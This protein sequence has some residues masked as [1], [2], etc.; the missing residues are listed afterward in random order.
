MLN[1]QGNFCPPKQK[2]LFLP[3]DQTLMSIT[4]DVKVLV[5]GLH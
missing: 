3:L 4:L 2:E 5:Q 1:V